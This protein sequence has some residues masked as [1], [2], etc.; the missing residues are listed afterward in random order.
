MNVSEMLLD[1]VTRQRLVPAAVAAPVGAL[2]RER[3]AS[4]QVRL[5]VHDE[6]VPGLRHHLSLA[7]GTGAALLFLVAKRRRALF[8]VLSR[9][10]ST[11]RCSPRIPRAAGTSTRGS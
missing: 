6:Q 2:V 3:A 7:D 5:K 10:T 11:S 1:G 8:A 9:L 4:L